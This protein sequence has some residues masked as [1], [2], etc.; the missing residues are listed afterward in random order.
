MACGLAA[1][2]SDVG[3]IPDLVKHGE[4][5]LLAAP[6]DA[7]Q[8]AEGLA[9]LIR[10]EALRLRLGAAARRAVEAACDPLTVAARYLEIYATAQAAWKAR[11]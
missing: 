1:V 9:A 2:A 3:G 8:L 7:A 5:G 4:T 6:G 11:G 10:D